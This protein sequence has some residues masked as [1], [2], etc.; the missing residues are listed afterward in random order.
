MHRPETVLHPTMWPRS[1]CSSAVQAAPTC[2][3][4]GVMHVDC[5]AGQTVP[6]LH[7][8]RTHGSPAAVGAAQIPQIASP[9]RAQKVL[10]HCASS[11]QAAPT[12]SAPGTARHTAPKSPRETV[13]HESAAIDCAQAVVEA[14]VVL[15]E[16]APTVGRQPCAIRRLQVAMS[17]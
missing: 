16:G 5:P 17:P 6:A 3:G 11:P 13:L 7:E 1:H 4:T 10:A 8:P 2:P 15:L 12:A 14:T 9:A